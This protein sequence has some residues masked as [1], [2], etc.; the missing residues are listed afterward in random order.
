MDAEGAGGKQKGERCLRWVMGS[1]TSV[2]PLAGK[3]EPATSS[4][5]SN[6][7]LCFSTHWYFFLES[8]RLQAQQVRCAAAPT[9]LSELVLAETK[10]L[11]LRFG[12]CQERWGLLGASLVIQLCGYKPNGEPGMS[13]WVLLLHLH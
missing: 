9:S 2:C 4:K 5:G 11:Q 1:F 13:P 8:H 7:S 3:L 6:G 12:G 10:R